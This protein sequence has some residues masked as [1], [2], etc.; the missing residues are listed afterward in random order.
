MSKEDTPRSESIQHYVREDTIKE[1]K[2]MLDLPNEIILIIL[3][4]LGPNGVGSMNAV[5][6]RLNTICYDPFAFNKL[7]TRMISE[8]LWLPREQ[9]SRAG[10]ITWHYDRGEHEPGSRKAI[11]GYVASTKM[12]KG[13]VLPNIIINVAL[14]NNMYLMKMILEHKDTLKLFTFNIKVVHLVSIFD[15]ITFVSNDITTKED[16]NAWY[17]MISLAIPFITKL[18]KELTTTTQK[19]S[20]HMK[21]FNAVFV[22]YNPAFIRP[23]LNAIECLHKRGGKYKTFI[24]RLSDT[25]MLHKKY[26]GDNTKLWKSYTINAGTIRLRNMYKCYDILFAENFISVHKKA[27][28]INVIKNC[29]EANIRYI[30]GSGCTNCAHTLVYFCLSCVHAINPDELFNKKSDNNDTTVLPDIVHTWCRN[31][32]YDPHELYLLDHLRIVCECIS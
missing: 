29:L 4:M 24:H 31:H 22:K 19:N 28:D 14:N 32:N 6:V 9:K 21:L 3:M 27:Y 13:M 11:T 10:H 8:R 5:C 23:L 25:V 7:S 12:I 15:R 16:E 26:S 2:G 30:N 20:W 1:K 17:K 18:Y